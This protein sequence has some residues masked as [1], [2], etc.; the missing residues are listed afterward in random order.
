MVFQ[1]YNSIVL[2]TDRQTE[3]LLEVLSDLKR[4]SFVDCSTWSHNTQEIEDGK[5]KYIFKLY[6]IN[7]NR[8]K[9]TRN[10]KE[11]WLKYKDRFKIS[12]VYQVSINTQ[13]QVC[14]S[15]SWARSNALFCGQPKYFMRYFLT[16]NIFIFLYKTALMCLIELCCVPEWQEWWYYDKIMTVANTPL[17][18]ASH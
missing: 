4:C 5:W 1:C 13:G 18:S 3:P 12:W 8:K 11:S 15:Y 7:S 6:S 9:W 17:V 10:W 14:Q 2:Q 16:R